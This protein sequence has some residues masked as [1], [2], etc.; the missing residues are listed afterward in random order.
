[1]TKALGFMERNHLWSVPDHH[2][3]FLHY[4]DPELKIRLTELLPRQ[5]ETT[6]EGSAHK[7]LLVETWRNHV[8]LLRQL[9]VGRNCGTPAVR[10]PRLYTR[11]VPFGA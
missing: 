2:H 9:R 6:P 7:I 5:L 4:I 10:M 8:F 11:K 1:M 3:A